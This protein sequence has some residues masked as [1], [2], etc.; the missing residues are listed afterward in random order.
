MADTS[1]LKFPS[2]VDPFSQPVTILMPD[3]SPF[4][5]T[6]DELTWFHFSGVRWGINYGASVGATA[7]TLVALILLTK[8]DKRRS[9][10][11]VL[12]L[13]AL[14]FNLVRTVLGALYST[15]PFQNPYAVIANDWRYITGSDKANSIAVPV[16]KVL[17]LVCIELSLLL[18][19][20]VVMATRT[21]TQRLAVLFTCSTVGLLA[22]GFSFA[23]MVVNAR[24]IMN[25]QSGW[26]ESFQDM[27]HG[28]NITIIISLSLF[29]AVFVGKLGFA[30]WQRRRLGMNKF[31]PMQVVFIM[32]IQTMI[33]PSRLLRFPSSNRVDGR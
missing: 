24:M 26:G 27:V 8:P 33:V 3:G 9:P 7:V 17:L 32:G 11:F 6:M 30:M 31:G 29:T 23:V 14:V 13:L 5:V 22:V 10:I 12:N 28:S 16:M 19:I 4:N 2:P 25:L 18:Q 20:H 1:F 15:S 21:R